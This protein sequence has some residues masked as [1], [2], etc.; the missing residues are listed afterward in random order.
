LE[1]RMLYY[2]PFGQASTN[3]PFRSI[4][5]SSGAS[6]PMPTLNDTANSGAILTEGSDAS[7]S[8]TALTFSSVT[9]GAYNFTSQL[10]KVSLQLEQDS[11]AAL[12]EIIMDPLAERLGRVR[13]TYC[14]TGT[15]SSEPEGFITG[16]TKGVATASN[17][18]LAQVDLESLQNSVDH[19]YQNGPKVGWQMHQNIASAIRKLDVSAANYSQPMWQPSL[20]LGK[21]DTILGKQ[22]WINNSMASAVSD[23]AKV[24]AYGDFSRFII[25]D[26]RGVQMLRLNERY[27]ELYA[28]GMV[29]FQRWDS[30]VVQTV[31]IKYLEIS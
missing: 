24:V 16:A 31:A 13:N 28:V 10:L 19:A 3:A 11:F 12:S 25:R 17:D 5:T 21:P 18:A 15:G 6:M 2:G 14:T 27:A 8:P 9:F 7:S 26:I 1:R 23:A 4:V 30:K 29:G 22:Y 20:A